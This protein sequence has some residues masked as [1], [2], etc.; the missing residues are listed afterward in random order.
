[1]G[2]V[3]LNT[4]GD[5]LRKIVTE[6]INSQRTVSMTFALVIILL[7][8]SFSLSINLSLKKSPRRHEDGISM[9]HLKILSL[10]VYYIPEIISL[11][12]DFL[13]IL[14]AVQ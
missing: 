11:T 9:K 14:S 4:R 6:M 7:K 5:R 13:A 3:F 8:L 2:L 12:R 1:M 10:N